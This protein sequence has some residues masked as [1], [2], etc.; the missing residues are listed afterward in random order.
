[1]EIQVRG[2]RKALNIPILKCTL[3][4]NLEQTHSGQ[5]VLVA[6][7]NMSTSRFT[8][9]KDFFAPIVRS[10]SMLCRCHLLRWVVI[11]HG[12][13]MNGSEH[14]TI[15]G[16]AATHSCQVKRAFTA[17]TF[18][19]WNSVSSIQLMVIYV[20]CSARWAVS[21]PGGGSQE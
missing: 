12:L 14:Q 20:R 6:E 3:H 17:I 8:L 15:L 21:Y 10:P 19:I 7:C 4:F 18:I 2:V 9:T 11:P 5:H 13:P 1:M 16:L